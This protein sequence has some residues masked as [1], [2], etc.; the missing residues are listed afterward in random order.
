MNKIISTDFWAEHIK[1]ILHNDVNKSII[2]LLWNS[3]DADAFNVEIILEKN[4]IWWIECL[5]IIDDWHWL[6]YD[7]A[8]ENFKVLWLSHKKS[9]EY[10]PLNRRYHWK[11]WHWRYSFSNLWK[12]LKG[13]SK[14]KK[15]W[16][17]FYYNFTIDSD[18][19]K[20][21]KFSETKKIDGDDTWFTLE[22]TLLDK[23]VKE[24][25]IEKLKESII[26]EFA[27][28]IKT[29]SKEKQ[30]LLS[31]NWDFVDIESAIVKR[32]SFS[33]SIPDDI[34]NLETH[35]FTWEIIHWKSNKVHNRYFC[36]DE[37]I[38]LWSD[39][40]TWFSEKNF[41][42]SVYIKWELL[43][44]RYDENT[45]ELLKWEIIFD[46]ISNETK[47][48]ISNFFS[49]QLKEKTIEFIEELKDDDIYPYK[50]PPKNQIEEEER[51]LYDVFLYKIHNKSNKIFSWT[52]D[53]KKMILELIKNSLEKDPKSMINILK[54]VAWLTKEDLE[55]LSLMINKYTLVWL[56][57]VSKSI[58]DKISFLWE[59]DYLIHGELNK[60]IKERS[61]LHKILEQELWVFWD[62]YTE[63]TSDKSM[64]AVLEKHV[65]LLWRE[66]L[67]ENYDWL[68]NNI[69]DLFLY[70]QFPQTNENKL[71]HLVIELK[72]PWLKL[73][74]TELTQIKKYALEVSSDNR[75]DKENTEW[76][77]V[78]ISNEYNDE[79]AEE[80]TQVNRPR[81]CAMDKP[82]YKVYI[83]TW[84]EILQWLRW[85]YSFLK[86]KLDN[87]EETPENLEYIKE[88]MSDIYE[89]ILKK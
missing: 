36:T 6:D 32:E 68:S 86:S 40:N 39:S 53:S 3:F 80:I 28:Y 83:K 46:L 19:L 10:S 65:K 77:F 15:N 37:W 58:T 84:W 11:K 44:K 31:I 51:N 30:I 42:H 76:E 49:N 18:S 14:Y 88:N 16:E 81:W 33:F 13:V 89:N 2:E 27:D 79:V 8:E 70:K 22:I 56:I 12:H 26:L 17:Y 29:Y 78:L 48:K 64:R 21:M 85:K 50:D 25:D 75:F 24:I 47:N 82:H 72:R 23:K 57:K 41:W 60:T 4:E 54:S 9:K 67:I 35:K 7:E 43:R 87:F 55:S 71:K 59:L 1:N 61:H 63:W 20:D 45:H 38:V 66:K 69:P 73:T 52:K 5:K 74:N 34:N 62:W